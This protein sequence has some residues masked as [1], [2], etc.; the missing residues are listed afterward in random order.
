V[1][2][3][4]KL[5]Y[6][7]VTVG[8]HDMSEPI[9]QPARGDTRER[10]RAKL[11]T[12]L[13]SVWA[14]A[15]IIGFTVNAFASTSHGLRGSQSHASQL[16]QTRTKSA[17]TKVAK[18]AT[19]TEPQAWLGSSIWRAGPCDV[20]QNFQTF[21]FSALPKVEVGSGKPGE[22]E[23]L[24]LLRV[25]A[26]EDGLIQ[27]ETRVCAPVGCNQTVERYKKLDAN[28]MQEWHFEGRLPDHEP[29][30]I[31]ANGEALDGS[32]PGRIFNRCQG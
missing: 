31:V 12:F 21:A 4:P 26:V 30:V 28:R 13:C 15:G 2:T 11:V 3:Y 8:E 9:N 29:Y 18:A 24:E 32:G 1:F 25:A 23:R 14:G 27:I 17:Q 10:D 20:A 5:I 16:S 6:E 22:G 7:T 19:A